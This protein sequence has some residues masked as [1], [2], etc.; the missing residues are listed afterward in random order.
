VQLGTV[1]YLGRFLENPAA[2]PTQVVGWTARE[3]GVPAS[4]DLAGYGEGEWRC[5]HQA[6][7]R[8]VY[9]YRPFNSE[10]VEPELVE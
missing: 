4:L 6:E 7:I 5:S 8:R 10:G 1:R 2:V 3:I 9:G